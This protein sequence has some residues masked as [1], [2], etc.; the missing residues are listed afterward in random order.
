MGLWPI[1]SSLLLL[2]SPFVHMTS[3]PVL[4][5]SPLLLAPPPPPLGTISSW[6]VIFILPINSA[7][8]PILYTLTTRPFK[9]TILQVWANYRQRRPLLSGQQTHHPSLTWQEMWPLQENSH[10]LTAGQ[11]IKITNTLPKLTPVEIANDG[12]NDVTP[13][14]QQPQQKQCTV[15]TVGSDKKNVLHTV[16]LAQTDELI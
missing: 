1:I 14:T 8:N 2:F 7:L 5:P 15:L 9:E 3:H 12:Y 6:V 11:S 13:C 10:D 16:S 4:C